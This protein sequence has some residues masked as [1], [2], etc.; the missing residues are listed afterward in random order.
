MQQIPLVP[1]ATSRC[2]RTFPSHLH[3]LFQRIP[4]TTYALIGKVFPS[5]QPSYFKI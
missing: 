3:R 2:R 1:L 5:K 4:E